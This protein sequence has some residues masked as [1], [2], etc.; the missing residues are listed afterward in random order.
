[1]GGL[2]RYWW[3]FT[4]LAIALV[5]TALVFV[6]LLPAVTGVT[7]LDPAVTG[8]QVRTALGTFPAQVMFPTSVSFTAL[9]F[10]AVLSVVK[11][12]GRTPWGVGQA[13]E[14][15]EVGLKDGP[16]AALQFRARGT[17]GPPS[18]LRT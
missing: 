14:Q 4:K 6:L 16:T 7:G 10:A 15:V 9:A 12:W 18:Y 11:P 2:L 13:G 17:E 5:L 1:M 3:V 8:D